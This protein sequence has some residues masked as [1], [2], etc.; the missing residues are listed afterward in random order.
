MGFAKSVKKWSRTSCFLTNDRF[1]RFGGVARV[2]LLPLSAA[3]LGGRWDAGLWRNPD[4]NSRPAAPR[5]GPLA[6]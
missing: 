2:L 3:S 1:R 5:F 4:L 6:L